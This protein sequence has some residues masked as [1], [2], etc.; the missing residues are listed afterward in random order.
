MSLSVESIAN[1][2]GKWKN[3]QLP[4]SKST[5]SRV[6][7]AKVKSLLVDYVFTMSTIDQNVD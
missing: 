2:R 3:H 7:D 6:H 1:L 4:K 5:Q